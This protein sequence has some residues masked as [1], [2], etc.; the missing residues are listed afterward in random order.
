MPASEGQHHHEGLRA[1]AAGH[2]WQ[3]PARSGQCCTWQRG[4]HSRVR[5]TLQTGVI[6]LLSFEPTG[7]VVVSIVGDPVVDPIEL[8][9]VVALAAILRAHLH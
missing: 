9:Q 3:L 5:G 1:I 4:L 7:E 8:G 6:Q 2:D